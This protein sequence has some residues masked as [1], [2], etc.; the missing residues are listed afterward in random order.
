[1]M[2]LCAPIHLRV[3]F[4]SVVLDGLR[5]VDKIVLVLAILG[6]LF[7]GLYGLDESVSIPR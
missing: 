3:F 4:S 5:R 7:L 2:L 6:E 1:M